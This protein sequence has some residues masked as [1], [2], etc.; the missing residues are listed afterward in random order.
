MQVSQEYVASKFSDLLLLDPN[1]IMVKGFFNE[2]C[3]RLRRSILATGNNYRRLQ[4][5][6]QPTQTM[7]TTNMARGIAVLRLDG[8]MY[9]STMD[10]LFNL[11]DLVPIGGYTIVDNY[12]SVKE[13]KSAVEEFLHIHSAIETFVYVDWSGMYWQKTAAIATNWTW[14]AN[15]NKQR[16]YS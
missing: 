12:G 4:N 13:A 6:P 8:D 15:F 5:K 16:Q 3:P 1:V 9:E 7:L 14:Y 2:S 10:T 11:Y